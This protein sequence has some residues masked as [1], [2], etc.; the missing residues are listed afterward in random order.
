VNAATTLGL[1]SVVSTWAGLRTFAP[2]RIPVCGPDPAVDGLWWLAG[3]GGYG[4]QTAPAMA[5]ALAGLL[6]DGELPD[7]LVAAGVSAARL[8]PRRLAPA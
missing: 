1:R 7:A 4:I 5:A 3:Q 6:V 2:D 8:D